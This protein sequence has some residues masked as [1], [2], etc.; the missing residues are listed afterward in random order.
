M[1][2]INSATVESH[3]WGGKE[4]P[5]TV[6]KGWNKG[7]ECRC[8]QSCPHLSYGPPLS[9]C[10]RWGSGGD[11]L[12]SGGMSIAIGC[13]ECFG[14]V[15]AVFW[16]IDNSARECFYRRTVEAI[17]CQKGPRNGL[18]P[19]PYGLRNCL[20]IVGMFQVIIKNQA[21]LTAICLPI[22]L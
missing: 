20:K 22:G 4:V 5:N 13:Q 15:L 11:H 21:S 1:R 8:S 6:P 18:Y 9:P 2:L 14:S 19:P 16:R 12:H 17:S 7:S 10:E 3:L